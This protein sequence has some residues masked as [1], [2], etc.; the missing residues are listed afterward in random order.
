VDT[1]AS[2]LGSITIVA[3]DGSG[4]GNKA[5]NGGS[6]VNAVGYVGASGVTLLQAGLG[7]AT[8]GRGAAGGSITD[9]SILGGG[10]VGAELR[11]QAGDASSTSNAKVGGTGGSVK[12]LGVDPLENGTIFRRIVAGDGGD[13]TGGKGGL[14]GSVINVDVDG[15]IGVRRGQGF[16]YSFM[17]GIF[18]GLGGS[19]SSAGAAG[20]VTGISAD[21]IA[22]IVAGKVEQ[23][24][25]IARENLVTQ[26]SGIILNDDI[27]TRTDATGQYTNYDVANLVGAVVNPD[28]PG[29]NESEPQPHANTFDLEANEFVDN[30]ANGKFSIGDTTNERTDGF[31]AAL[32]FLNARKGVNSF[33]PE[34]LFTLDDLGG[35]EFIDLN[36]NNGQQRASLT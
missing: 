13:N 12:G 14:G 2:P 34:A 28:Q 5:G 10:G 3:G 31:I 8:A 4:A 36:N 24:S 26:V 22:A 32:S 16:G 17:G 25:V 19:G 1:G 27:A 11:V 20:S 23:G 18:A 15:D 6:I 29:A 33:R 30:D 9:V 35:V 21:A 7:G